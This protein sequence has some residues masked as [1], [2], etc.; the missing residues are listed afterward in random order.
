MNQ[1][2]FGFLREEKEE[3]ERFCLWQAGAAAVTG[4]F[5]DLAVNHC[6]AAMVTNY[7]LYLI[8]LGKYPASSP[9]DLFVRVHRFVRNGPILSIRRN[10]PRAFAAM[11]V[12]AGVRKLPI[13]FS[14]PASRKEQVLISCLQNEKCPA[15]L[16]VAAGPLSFHWIL[17]V[18]TVEYQNQRYLLVVTGWHRAPQRW[19]IDQGCRIF[20][21]YSL[22]SR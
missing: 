22:F 16:L 7:L 17:A 8:S 15:A 18:G 21:A 10:V 3:K 11:Q 1:K 14:T 19:R 20:A 12:P 2:K 9:R 6:C 5:A 13:H 4:D